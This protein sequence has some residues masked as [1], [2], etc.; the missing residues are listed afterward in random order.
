MFKE[1][2]TLDVVER[3]TNPYADI[4]NLYKSCS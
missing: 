3:G 1:A 2:S 4:F